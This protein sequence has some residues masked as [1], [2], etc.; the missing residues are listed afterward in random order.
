MADIVN[1]STGTAGVAGNT[2]AD[3]QTY[4]AANLLEVA[5]LRTVLNQHGDKV[6]V[7]SNSSRTIHFVREEKF[8]ATVPSQLVEGVRPDAI[9]MT[10]SQFEAV[11]EQYGVVVRISDLAELTAKHPIVQKT[12][13][14]LGLQSAEIYDQLIFSVI[15]AATNVYRPN[16]KAADTNLVGSDHLGYVD[17]A[18]ILA[19]LQDAGG[20]PLD[21]GDPLGGACYSLVC[22]P[23]VHSAFL[24]DPDFK[25]AAKYAAPQRIWH[26]QME[27][28]AGFRVV[29]SNAPAFAATA[30][31]TSGQ[32]SKVYS[33]FAIAARAYQISDLQN[34]QVYVTPPGGHGD[35]LHQNRSVGWKFAFKS[36]ITNQTWIRRLRSAGLNSVTNP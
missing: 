11:M 12:I 4:F 31:A 14:L 27:E 33:S 23:Q 35:E 1:V 7:P 10:L 29:V 8:S 9:P 22:P 34:L 28:L 26:G 16:G 21:G 24:K 17:L 6:P 5:E 13:Y 30:Q 3:M 25:E 20:M 2:V 32:S 19:L 18:E 15:D 36:L